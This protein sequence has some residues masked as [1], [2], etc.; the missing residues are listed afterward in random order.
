LQ[1]TRRFERRQL[2][3]GDEMIAVPTLVREAPQPIKKLIGTCQT[4]SPSSSACN[5]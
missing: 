2:A 1:I 5:Y 4:P 3:R